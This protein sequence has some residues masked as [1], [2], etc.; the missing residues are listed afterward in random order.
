MI[1]HLI[2]LAQILFVSVLNGQMSTESFTKDIDQLYT[3]IENKHVAPYWNTSKEN[4]LVVIQNAKRNIQDKEICDESCYVEIFKVVSALNESHS[5]ISAKSRYE[6]FGYLPMTNKWFEDGL[7]IVKTSSEYQEI[8]GHNIVSVNGI[9]IEIVIEKLKQVIPHT[10]S[11]RIKKYIGS[12]LHLPGMLYGLGISENP[13]EAMFVFEKNGIQIERTIKKLSP[14]DEENTTFKTIPSADSYFQRNVNDYYWFDYNSE[15][16]LVY[17]QY[18]RIGNMKSESSTAFA[19]RLWATVDS[20]DIDKFVL[21]LRYNGGGSFPY[22]LKFIQGIIDRP[23]IN[24]R[25][26]LF[27]ITGYDT[28][29]AAIT[30]VN[31]LEQRTQAII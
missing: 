16:K 6:L 12:Y 20:V 23:K 30:M 15:Q 8:L 19:D 10:N 25:G 18:N 4:L 2:I 29:S 27:I 7:F 11:S 31:Q 14:E 24:K 28:F 9:D 1:R 3:L 13:S 21:D 5:Y 17:F 22:S 26:K